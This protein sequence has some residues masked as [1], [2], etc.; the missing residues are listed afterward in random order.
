MRQAGGRGL[1]HLC[2]ANMVAQ[3]GYVNPANPVAI[4][5]DAL[6]RCLSKLTAVRAAPAR[7]LPGSCHEAEP[8]QPGPGV[9]CP[10][11]GTK[12]P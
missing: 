3:H 1:N 4:R 8:A 2:V 5:Y 11:Q 7:W 9:F 12:G 6:A 10:D